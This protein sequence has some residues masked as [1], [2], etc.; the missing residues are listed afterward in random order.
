M[1][2]KSIGYLLERSA[3]YYLALGIGLGTDVNRKQMEESLNG[4][5][6]QIAVVE[7]YSYPKRMMNDKKKMI[8]FWQVTKS[9]FTRQRKLFVSNLMILSTNELEKIDSRFILYH[10]KNQ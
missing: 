6:E 2:S 9:F 5:E 7:K 3:K 4:L 1:I 8:D 10:R